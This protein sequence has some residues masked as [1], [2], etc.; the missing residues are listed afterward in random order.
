MAVQQLDVSMSN[1]RKWL[2]DMENDLSAPVVYM[3]CSRKEIQKK[4]QHQN[5][6]FYFIM[7]MAENVERDSEKGDV[8]FLSKEITQDKITAD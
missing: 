8:E 2:A 4:L 6:R 7:C 1:L 5:V 3:E